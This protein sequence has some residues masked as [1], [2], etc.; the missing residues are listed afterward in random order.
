GIDLGWS[1]EQIDR[2]RSFRT[3]DGRVFRLQDLVTGAVIDNS[4]GKVPVCFAVTVGQGA[5]TYRGRPADSLLVMDGFVWR[6]EEPGKPL[7]IDVESSY[8][9]L[10]SPDGFQARGV[11]DPAVYKDATSARL[12]RNWATG[13]IAVADELRKQKDFQR[14]ENLMERA[15]DL[16]PHASQAVDYLAYLY[17]EQGKAD[18]LRTLIERSG[19][20]NDEEL[21]LLLGQAEWK[22]DNHDGA[23]QAFLSILAQNHSNR[24]AL[25]EL[26]KLYF[27]S[28]RLPEVK[29]LLEEWLRYNPQD[30]RVAQMLAELEKGM[31]QMDSQ[32]MDSR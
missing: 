24:R 18:D 12:T 8:S 30:S 3:P 22:Q 5:R 15:V 31:G 23:E 28:E 17:A 6:V 4:G 29:R 19:R 32:V 7:R 9:F 13:F 26:V 14:T 16:I 25:Q 2:L 27:E 11:N 20:A 10:T 1:D 21:L